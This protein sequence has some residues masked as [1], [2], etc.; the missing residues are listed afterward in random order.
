MPM[1]EHHTGRRHFFRDGLARIVGPL[2][3]YLDRHVELPTCRVKLRPPGAIAE[4]DLLETCIRC[5]VCVE[6]CPAHAIRVEPTGEHSSSG[7]S[8]ID[9]DLAACVIC[10]GL[11]CTHECPS[12]ALRPIDRASDIAMGLARV[13]VAV[14]L[15][16]DGE[17]CTV[18]VERCPLGSEALILTGPGPPRVR[19]PGCVG[20]GLCQLSCPT[21]PKA[22]VV[23]PGS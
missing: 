12:G 14:C 7:T 4:D 22:I 6:V 13:N 3:D 18:C 19:D 21:T 9:P 11:V 16:L 15:R 20:C 17:D 10:D 1:D 2:A 5:G 23:R 8:Y